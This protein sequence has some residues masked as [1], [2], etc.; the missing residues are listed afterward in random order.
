MPNP[1]ILRLEQFTRLS[2]EDK[3]DIERAS[4]VR[5][6]RLAPREVIIHEGDPPKHVNLILSGWACRYKVLEDGRRQN[7][8]FSLPGDFCDLK[9]FIL[10]QM[11]HSIAAISAV[12]LAEVPADLME[13]LTSRN[14][15]LAKALW[16]AS[17]VMEAVEREW[18]VN[19]GQREAVERLAHLLC[20]LFYRLRAVGLTQGNSYHLPATQSELA[21]TTGMSP[22]HVNRSV[23]DLRDAGLIQQHGR[24]LTLPDLPRLEAFALF[25]PN[26]LHLSRDGASLD[27]NHT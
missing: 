14:S 26:Y 12:T 27:A 3:R 24:T 6:R 9:V 5:V 22:V 1:L 25:N 20:E 19:L 10:K 4:S 8:N 15:R 11:D 23:K 17:L 16:W 7:L 18:I 21:E 13:E 2:S